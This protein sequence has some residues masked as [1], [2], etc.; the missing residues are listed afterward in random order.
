MSHQEISLEVITEKYA[1]GQEK[2]LASVAEIQDAVYTRVS[3]DL[4]LAEKTKAK[5]KAFAKKFRWAYDNGLVPAGRVASVA[6]TNLQATYINCFVQPMEDRIRGFV[7]GIPGIYD[8]ITESAETMRR[9]GGVGYAFDVI[10]PRGA[11]VKGTQSLASGPVSYMR[12]FNESCATVESAGARRGAQM[13]VMRIDHPDIYEFVDAKLV[14]GQLTNFNISVGVTQE[15]FEA[16]V[17]E[18]PFQLVHKAEPGEAIKA[19]GAFQREDGMW[20]YREIDAQDL[21]NKVMENTYNAA[22]PGI[23]LLDNINQ[24]N[25]LWY[26]ETIKATNPC[27]EQPLPA[28]G[29]C[30]LSSVNLTQMIVNAFKDDARF[31]EKKF[32]E[33]VAIAVRTLDNVLD[34]TAWPL[35]QQRTEAMNKRRVG[36]GYTGLGDALIMLGL[37]Y[38]SQEGRDMAERITEI[39]R[40]E[41]YMASVELAKE[42]GAFP[43]FDA[44]KYLASG[45]AKRLPPAIRDAIR[46]HGIR[47]SHLLSIAPTGTISLAFADNA[48]NG[49]EPAFSWTYKRNKRVGDGTVSID[50]EDHAFRVYR[51]AGGD[52]NKLPDSFVS[53]LEISAMDHLR[54]MKAIQPYVDSSL[55]KTVNVPADYPFEDFKSLYLEAW[56][57]GLKGLATF[58]PNDVTGAVLS[59]GD[60]KKQGLETGDPDR[61]ISLDKAPVPALASLRWPSRPETPAGNPAVTYMVNHPESPFAVFI[62]HLENGHKQPFEVWVNGS[63]QPRGLGALAKS[64]STDMR[65]FDRKWLKMKLEALGQSAGSAFPMAFPPNGEQQMVA[66]SVSALAK[67]VTY[68]CNNLGA[69]DDIEDSDSPMV[70]ALFSLKEPKSGTDGTLSWTVDVKN[71]ATG[72]DFALF[73]KE[74]VMPDGSSRPYSVWFS[75][76]FPEAYTGLCKSLSLDMRVVDLAWVAKKLRSLAKFSEPRSD[77]MARVPGSDKQATYPSTVAYVATLILHRYQ[78]L[79]LLDE[80]GYPKVDMGLMKF[81]SA[82]AEKPMAVSGMTVT[83]GKPCPECQVPAVIKRDGCDFCTSCGHVGSCG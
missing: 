27:G 52:T 57:A 38:D 3:E 60:E 18:K 41:A 34:R 48:S 53:A 61:K 16:L 39:M 11:I 55:S 81:D 66:S 10:R 68:Q 46:E 42:K 71:V 20:V 31:D 75:G 32:R 13:G 25:N 64:L 37:R 5:Q 9:G 33:V 80:R 58:R 1:K 30:C 43:L 21:F 74:L 7:D 17:E 29:C 77:F 19:N 24:D 62:G 78:Q 49:L 26:C 83:A 2:N 59:T 69:F 72:E 23:L 50:V 51:L 73:L 36:L 6:G 47:N 70:D 45:F 63:E 82:E 15:F 4:A 79:G 8:A 56:R 14:K 35:E 28:Y 65:S 67:L 44:E 54:M 40:D 76:N 12:V 22:E